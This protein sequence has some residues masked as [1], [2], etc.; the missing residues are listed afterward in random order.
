LNV[1][2][3]A[4]AVGIV[5]SNYFTRIF[6]RETGVSPSSFRRSWH[7]LPRPAHP[8]AFSLEPASS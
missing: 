1:T 7:R 8:L 2:E 6:R 5:D 3:I 4:G